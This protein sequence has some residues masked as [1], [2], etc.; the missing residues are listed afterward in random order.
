MV[1][2]VLFTLQIASILT[3][4]KNNKIGMHVTVPVLFSHVYFKHQVSIDGRKLWFGHVSQ[5]LYILD[6]GSLIGGQIL[7]DPPG[8]LG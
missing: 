3:P 7:A 8:R 6:Q 5:Y 1:L 4:N 2:M